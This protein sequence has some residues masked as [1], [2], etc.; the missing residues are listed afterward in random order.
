MPVAMQRRKLVISLFGTG[1]NDEFKYD[2]YFS[3]IPNGPTPR[4]A[5]TRG[6]FKVAMEQSPKPETIALAAADAEFGHNACEGARDNARQAGLRIV[7]DK[8]YPPAT[9]D[10]SPIVRAVQAARPDLFVICSYPLDS[11]GMIRAMHEVG[12]K[13]KMWGG[14]M[15]GPQSTVFKTQLGPLLNGLV[16]NDNWLPVQAMQF[17]G[18][19][20]LLAKYQERAKGQGVD[21]L[22]YFIPV[23]AYS[24]LQLLQ[25][26]IEATKSFDEAKLADHMHNASF[27]L[28]VGDVRFTAL[29]EWVEERP[30]TVQFQGIKG[31]T[32]DD[33]RDIAISP[34]LHPPQFKSGSVIYPYEKAVK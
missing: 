15:I 17:P 22:G 16:N 10:F 23:W 6:F 8:S 19:M 27:K 34:I 1:I 25:Q 26:A 5:F 7:Y 11:V 4:P 14:A 3:M 2:R 33:V 31:N 21:P 12:F 20:E 24:Y 30:I 32:L 13:P 29:G 18:S 28:L 9:T